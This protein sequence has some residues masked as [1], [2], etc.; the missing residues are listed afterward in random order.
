MDLGEAVADADKSKAGKK[1]AY[2]AP[3][4]KLLSQN[5]QVSPFAS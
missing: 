5:S 2:K 3:W 4:A 1:R